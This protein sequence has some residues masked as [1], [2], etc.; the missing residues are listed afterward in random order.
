MTL[1]VRMERLVLNVLNYHLNLN[2]GESLS[3]IADKVSEMCGVSVRTVLNTRSDAQK[4]ELTVPRKRKS[5]V[6]EFNSREITYDEG[7]RSRIRRIGHDFFLENLRPTVDKI[8]DRVNE[9][10]D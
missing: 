3:G 6:S 7:T 10:D 2:N 4:G 5:G 8:L 9:D 1:S